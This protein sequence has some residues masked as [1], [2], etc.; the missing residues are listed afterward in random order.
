MPNRDV[1]PIDAIAQNAQGNWLFARL[2]S[3]VM[4]TLSSEQREAIHQVI[5]EPGRFAPPVNVRFTVPLF[6]WRFYLTV[7]GGEEKRSAER[8]AHDRNRYPLRTLAN[9]FFFVGLATL[10]YIAAIFALAIHS[11][12]I[13]F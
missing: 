9:I 1:P 5:C 10:F 2:P 11:A 8:R 4:D 12:I 3:W 7:V 6:T 13:E